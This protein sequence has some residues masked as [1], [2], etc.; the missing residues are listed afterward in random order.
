[1]NLLFATGNP[2]KISEVNKLLAT[3]GGPVIIG[4][5]EAGIQADVEETGAT[6]E[7]NAFLK[8]DYIRQHFGMDCFS[9]DT[10]LEVTALG[11]APGVHSARFAGPDKNDQANIDKL[12]NLLKDSGDRDA[13]FRTVICLLWKGEKHFFEGI[14]EGTISKNPA[15]T[16]GFGYDPVFVPK[17]YSISFAQMSALEKNAISH[18]GRAMQKLVGFLRSK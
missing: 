16:S 6:L 14:V 8:A 7:E 3:T 1:M 9:E 15:G 4:L 5:K 10:G 12:L 13:R 2:H 18:R 17:G 11:G